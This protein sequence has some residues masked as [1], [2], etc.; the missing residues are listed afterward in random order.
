MAFAKVG[1]AGAALD[2]GW[3]SKLE[4]FWRGAPS[5]VTPVAVA[6]ADWQRAH[7]PRLEEVLELAK[8]FSCGALLVDTYHKDG[9]NL[10]EILGEAL[11]RDLVE[12]SHRVE[13][14][15]V[16]AGSLRRSD[17]AVVSEM[18]ADIIAVRGAVCRGP[19]TSRVEARLVRQI[20]NELTL[21][22]C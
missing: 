7:A 13:L 14:R 20:K 5:T 1:L 17:M 12:S 15:I 4:S 18:G 22:R 11:I 19:R 3:A 16:L 21:S 2:R 10:L 8:G 9:G 6:Y